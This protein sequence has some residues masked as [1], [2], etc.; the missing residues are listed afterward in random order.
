MTIVFPGTSWPA[1]KTTGFNTTKLANA[2]KYLVNRKPFAAM[3]VW[4]G[5]VVITIG[6][7]AT[8]KS[9]FSVRKSLLSMLFGTGVASGAIDINDTMQDLNILDN[10]PSLTVAEQQATVRHLLQVRS[11][12]YHEAAFE[13]S[14][15]KA[16]RPARGSHAPGTFWWYNNWDFNTAGAIYAML[17]G[18][19]IATGFK[20]RIATPT[21]M[22]D[23]LTSHVS[24]FFE[25]ESIYPAY[26]FSMTV[27]DMARAALLMLAKGKWGTLQVIPE[28]WVVESTTTWTPIPDADGLGYGYF[29]FKMKETITGSPVGTVNIGPGAYTAAGNGGQ[30]LFVIPQ[31]GLAVAWTVDNATHPD[32]ISRTE[33]FNFIA[34][35]VDAKL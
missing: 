16:E 33:A 23:F 20:N 17:T 4:D 34:M 14:E 31:H 26:L 25:S 10:A 2:R 11:G 7:T 3:A 24:L 32:D 5:Q 22:Q 15:Q 8:R 12:V 28:S 1:V 27:R 9:L 18:E 21:K 13:T 35:L 30:R 29:W 6:P 19:S